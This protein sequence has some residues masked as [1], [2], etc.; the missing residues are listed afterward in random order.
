MMTLLTVLSK[1]TVRIANKIRSYPKP[2]IGQAPLPDV[3]G[4][5]RSRVLA[6]HT[7][8]SR[9]RGVGGEYR[10]ADRLNEGY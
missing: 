3:A 5:A 8:F 6:S 4:N 10:L 1:V 9:N 7:V 2:Q